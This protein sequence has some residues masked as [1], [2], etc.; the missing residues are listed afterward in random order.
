MKKQFTLIELL[1]VIAIIAILASMLLPALNQA[2][3]RARS[4]SCIS[5]LKQQGSLSQMYSNDN[6]DFLVSARGWNWSYNYGY[7]WRSSTRSAY[8]FDS[9][10]FHCPSQTI[11]SF[12]EDPYKLRGSY[13]M[14]GCNQTAV[15][16]EN[17]AGLMNSLSPLPNGTFPSRKISQI[18]SASSVLM[19][20]EVT[21][22]TIV[23]NSSGNIRNFNATSK[24]NGI[25]HA[26]SANFCFVDGHAASYQQAVVYNE[27]AYDSAN[28]DG[29]LWYRYTGH[30]KVKK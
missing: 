21:A 4:T 25:R 23:Y 14:N 27:I 16:G 28:Y 5:N 7:I 30:M 24:Q 12:P 29:P 15:D 1:V 6:N 20:L 11:K 3:E 2:R 9:K 10:I 19:F 18:R 13:A 26:G 8:H 22:D 17:P